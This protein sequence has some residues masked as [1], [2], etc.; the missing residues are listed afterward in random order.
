MSKTITVNGF[1][2]TQQKYLLLSKSN[3]C[4]LYHYVEFGT[5]LPNCYI[6]SMSSIACELTL[7]SEDRISIGSNLGQ[8][9]QYCHQHLVINTLLL[10]Q[11]MLKLLVNTNK[12]LHATQWKKYAW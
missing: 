9:S 7:I 6:I 2:F 4:I 5:N 3:I 10:A 8:R 12:D 11:E 1:S